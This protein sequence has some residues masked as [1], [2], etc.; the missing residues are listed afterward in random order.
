MLFKIIMYLF[1]A[2]IVFER[3]QNTFSNKATYS[4]YKTKKESFLCFLMVFLYTTIFFVAF[5]S[6][7][8]VYSSKKLIL[9]TIIGLLLWFLGVW[10]RRISI[11]A[12]GKS[13]SIY[14]TPQHLKRVIT[15]GAYKY[16]RHPYY[17]A[18]IVELVSYS[19]IFLSIP[20]LFLTIIFYLPLILLRVSKEENFLLQYF[21]SKY[22]TYKKETPLIFNLPAFMQSNRLMNHVRQIIKI[23]RRYG[24]KHLTQIILMDKAVKRYFRNYIISQNIAALDKIGFVNL[25]LVENEIDIVDFSSKNNLNLSILKFCCD[26]LYVVRIFNKKA[27]TYSLTHYGYNL[28][29]SSRGVFDFI[30]AYAPVFEN[31]EFL[32]TNKKSYGKDIFRRGEFVGRASAALAEL[33]PFPIARALLM[34]YNLYRILDL[35]S[36][37]GDFLIGFCQEN[38]M[39]G[40]GIDISVEAVNYANYK[41]QSRKVADKVKFLVGDILR[42]R[43][44]QIPHQEIDVITCMFVLHEFLATSEKLVTDVFKSINTAFPGKHILV[45]ELTRCSLDHLFNSPSGIVEHHFFHNLSNQGLAAL[46]EWKSIFKKSGLEIIEE[47]RLSMAEQSIFLL[48]PKSVKPKPA[49]FQTLTLELS[50]L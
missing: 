34:K 21:P 24:W 31:L 5:L 12:L 23:L 33:F 14:R 22:G 3:V 40:L 29:T 48:K 41:A 4:K 38:K 39:K 1:L 6:G 9:I 45:C 15:F 46:D 27:L 16:S 26:Y 43:E 32:I 10:Y 11:R 44:V 20:A 18:S 28:F 30:H 50:Q 8:R 42:L 35:G 2:F 7:H 36:G 19:L 47:E 37:S 13:W 49:N 25:M 17:A